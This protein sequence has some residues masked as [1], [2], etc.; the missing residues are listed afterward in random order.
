MMAADPMNRM[1]KKKRIDA[2]RMTQRT[3]FRGGML[4]RN[5]AMAATVG[6]GGGFEEVTGAGDGLPL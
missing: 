6:D 5:A 2:A 4:L 3:S 1:K